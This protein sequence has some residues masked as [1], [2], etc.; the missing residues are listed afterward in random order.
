MHSSEELLVGWP[1]AC[2]SCEEPPEI[3]GVG[4]CTPVSAEFFHPALSA[5]HLD[6]RPMF[7]VFF[8]QQVM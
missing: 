2:S 3:V 7:F 1:S 6:C 5:G 4:H 8:K